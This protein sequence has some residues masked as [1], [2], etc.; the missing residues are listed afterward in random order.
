MTSLSN[1]SVASLNLPSLSGSLQSSESFFHNHQCH[2]SDNNHFNLAQH[3]VLMEPILHSQRQESLATSNNNEQQQQQ[4]QR[5]S[6]Q[7]KKAAAQAAEGD[8]SDDIEVNETIFVSEKE[9]ETLERG[10]SAFQI[11]NLAS[12]VSSS[13]WERDMGMALHSSSSRHLEDD[14]LIEQQQLLMC[15]SD[16]NHYNINNNNDNSNR[17]D[18]PRSPNLQPI[19]PSAFKDDADGFNVI[20]DH[21]KLML[22]ERDQQN[23]NNQMYQTRDFRCDRSLRSVEARTPPGSRTGSIL[24]HSLISGVGPMTA[25]WSGSNTP[26]TTVINNISNQNNN[27]PNNFNNSSLINILPNVNS[28]NVVVNNNNNN[29][30]FRKHNS[31]SIQNGSPLQRHISSANSNHDSS[32]KQP[33]P[34]QFTLL[35][36]KDVFFHPFGTVA[37]DPSPSTTNNNHQNGANKQNMTQNNNS[38]SLPLHRSRSPS[39]YPSQFSSNQH[40][41]QHN[42][43]QQQNSQQHHDEVS[44]VGGNHTVPTT[45]LASFC[46]MEI[47]PTPHSPLPAAAA[48]AADKKSSENPPTSNNKGSVSL[49][50]HQAADVAAAPQSI[51]KKSEVADKVTKDEDKNARAEKN[52]NKKKIFRGMMARASA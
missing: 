8:E 27:S 1:F 24:Q 45:A 38:S 29:P 26:A 30:F 35:N 17:S 52:K 34:Q 31:S 6:T 16:P 48:A 11:H 40:S 22:Q 15:T 47:L 3:R 41:Q 39:F 42:P 2:E 44:A 4:E 19:Q 28:N 49:T 5:N 9:I 50:V 36:V 14:D 18:R 12:N 23:H 37:A 33:P 13:G 25:H 10:L 21:F 51:N 46:S 32:S 43:P 20:N 7:K